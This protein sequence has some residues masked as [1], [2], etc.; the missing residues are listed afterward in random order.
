MNRKIYEQHDAAF[1]YV[2]AYVIMRGRERVGTV[3]FKYPRDGA[4]RLYA[5]VHFLGMPMVRG[6]ANGYGYDKRTAAVENAMSKIDPGYFGSD[7]DYRHD[8]QKEKRACI[9]FRNSV[10][11]ARDGIGW[12]TAMSNAGFQ[13]LQAV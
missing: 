7:H 11:K 4:G 3:A 9:R 2:N 5:Y 12:E 6:Y 13:V 1:R 10:L 8:W